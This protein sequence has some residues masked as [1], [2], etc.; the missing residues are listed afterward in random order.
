MPPQESRLVTT[1]LYC[2]RLIGRERELGALIEL[3]RRA[4]S[5]EGAIALVCGDA[6]VGKT[7]TIDELCRR[8][9]RGMRCH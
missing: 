5:G 4:A 1:P 7:R 2:P 8:L 9:P 3:A 6:G